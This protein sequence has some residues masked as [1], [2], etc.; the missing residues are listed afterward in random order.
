MAI[1]LGEM[2][3]NSRLITTQQLDEALKCQVIFGGRLGTNLIE[4]GYL[5]EEALARVLSEKLGAPYADPQLLMSLPGEVTCLL[6]RD[7]IERYRVIPLELDKKRLCIAMADPSDLAAIDEIAFMTGYIIRPFV[8]PEVRLVTALEKYFGIKREFRYISIARK[9][10]SQKTPLAEVAS[11]PSIAE[12]EEFVDFSALPE[13]LEVVQATQPISPE[14]ALIEPIKDEHSVRNE[15]LRRYTIDNL[16]MDL[17]DAVDRDEIASVIISYLGQEYERAAIFLLR[18]GSIQ[19]WKAL[20]KGAASKDFDKVEIPLTDK[21]VLKIVVD[22]K[23]F[24]LGPVPQHSANLPLLE[25]LGGATPTTIC[26]VPLMMMGKVVAILFV[27]DPGKN[28]NEGLPE[29]QKVVA[30]A[31][32]A[33]EILILRNKIMSM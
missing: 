21:S 9:G 19:G 29:L 3:V 27:N 2:L 4:L 31:S 18:G 16:S 1:K 12:K 11:A 20:Y 17:A 25:V 13:P 33:F 24:Y 14:P 30:K 10:R 23:S 6:P 15:A 7:I 8:T 32:M 26:L 22:G 5:E 28:I